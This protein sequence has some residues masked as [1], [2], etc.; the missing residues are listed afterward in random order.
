MTN[1]SIG[2]RNIDD[3]IDRA[4]RE[5]VQIDPLPGLRFRV[6]ARLERPPRGGGS[7]WLRSLAF[8]RGTWEPVAA[9]AVVAIALAVVV[10]RFMRESTPAPAT[11]GAAIANA[12]S[13]APSAP[14]AP[15]VSSATTPSV[16]PAAATRTRTRAVEPTPESIFG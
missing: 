14:P 15:A 16:Q 13:A 8:L 9:I 12:P 7:G 2:A 1:D 6:L 4:I 5:M 11:R 3:A 10:P